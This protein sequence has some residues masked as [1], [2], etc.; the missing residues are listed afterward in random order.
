MHVLGLKVVG[1]GNS[2][3][4]KR[5]KIDIIIWSKDIEEFV[6]NSLSPSKVIKVEIDEK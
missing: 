1:K 4:V 2:R 6:A 3:G 5:R